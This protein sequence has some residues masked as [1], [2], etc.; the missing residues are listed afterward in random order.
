MFC[1]LGAPLLVLSPTAGVLVALVGWVTKQT[2]HIERR[3][4]TV[5]DR[6]KQSR[7]GRRQSDPHR[8]WRRLTWLLAAYIAYIS[9]RWLPASVRRLL[10]RSTA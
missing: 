5:S 7:N 2:A 3:Q 10:T 8:H 6:R 9:L 4:A 1:T